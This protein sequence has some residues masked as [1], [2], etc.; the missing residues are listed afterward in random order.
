MVDNSTGSQE[1][2][3]LAMRRPG[4]RWKHI[5]ATFEREAAL[6]RKCAHPNVLTCLGVSHCE[7]KSAIL[8]GYCEGGDC[9]QLLQRHGALAE[10]VALT[11]ARQVVLALECMHGR[12]V[13]HRDVKLENI[14]VASM[15]SAG[16][17]RVQLCDLGHACEIDGRCAGVGRCTCQGVCV[18]SVND[19][20][21]GTA[22]YAPPEV[23]QGTGWTTAADVWSTGV[24]LYA[25][26]ANE[27]LRWKQGAN[28]V[29]VPEISTKTSR[30]FAQVASSTR[31]ALK[32]LLLPEPVDRASLPSFLTSITEVHPTSGSSPRQQLRRSTL[33]RAY[34]LNHVPA[35]LETA[36]ASGSGGATHAARFGHLNS[37]SG[38]ASTDNS[39]SS[40]APS[41]LQASPMPPRRVPVQSL[42]SVAD[43]EGASFE[44][45]HGGTSSL[46][47]T[48]GL[49]G[50]P[51]MPPPLSMVLQQRS[52]PNPSPKSSPSQLRRSSASLA[53]PSEE[54]AVSPPQAQAPPQLLSSPVHPL[55]QLQ[56]EPSPLI[57]Q[58]PPVAA[59]VPGPSQQPAPAQQQQIADISD[60]AT[61]M[62]LGLNAESS[63]PTRPLPSP[64]APISL[65]MKSEKTA[66]LLARMQAARNGNMTW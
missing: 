37:A 35:L 51:G 27:M 47:L 38:N 64:A 32:S 20:F 60:D 18:G 46:S 50:L 36:G 34:S 42:A 61:L 39:P 7:S 56:P 23:A 33:S 59:P 30:A 17:P 4:M 11:I 16:L 45:A 19:G 52:S 12:G 10:R 55:P 9:L 57:P 53:P 3:K 13:L 54:E 15:D 40:S 24:V 49:P 2:V 66:A 26:L 31:V 8:L 65:K 29:H 22:G 43:E 63:A 14:L 5:L 41:S 1:A 6:L 58:Q 28:H 48:R 62:S 25:L 21:T 44:V